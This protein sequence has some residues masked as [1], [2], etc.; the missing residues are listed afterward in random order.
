MV[1]VSPVDFT[2]KYVGHDLTVFSHKHKEFKKDP[3]MQMPVRLAAFTNEVGTALQPVIGSKAMLASWV[4]ALIYVGAAVV[5]PK[6]YDKEQGNEGMVKRAAFQTL[7]SLTLPVLVVKA[8]QKITKTFMN[9]KFGADLVTKSLSAGGINKIKALKS[10]GGLAALALMIKP[11]DKFSEKKKK[12]KIIEP[13]Y[14]KIAN[15]KAKSSISA[16]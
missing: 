1:T 4:P 5:G 6:V 15:K 10:L 2:S 13:I 7:A 14:H 3:L 11:I 16:A 12:K 8:G 9:K